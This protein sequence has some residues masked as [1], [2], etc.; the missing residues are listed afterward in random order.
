MSFYNGILNLTSWLGNVIM[1]TIAGL[2]LAVAI[3][4]FAKGYP[5]SYAMWAAVA[6]LCVSGLLRH[7][8]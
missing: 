2:L 7:R 8:G 1:P 4:R 6:A 5:W 3:V